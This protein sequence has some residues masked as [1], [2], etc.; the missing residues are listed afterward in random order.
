M[1]KR[2]LKFFNY[3]LFSTRRYTEKH[4]WIEQIK[5][6]KKFLIGISDYAQEALGGVV[7]LSI[8][9][10][11]DSVK[12][13]NS[14][15][16]IES[17]KAVSEIYAPADLVISKINQEVQEDYSLINT[18]AETTWLVEVI[19]ENPDQIKNLMNKKNYDDFI[20]NI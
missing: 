16:E 11:G 20:K 9:E 4:E 5:D 10:I 15:L 13:N 8:P 19:L 18:S 1:N 14:I 3:R 12:K 7:Y 17:P 2:L 6:S